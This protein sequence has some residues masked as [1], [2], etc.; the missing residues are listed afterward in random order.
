LKIL[1]IDPAVRWNV[2]DVRRVHRFCAVRL[3]E[4]LDGF[5][6]IAVGA[7]VERTL[8]ARSS[9]SDRVPSCLLIVG[10]AAAIV[11]RCDHEVAA[12]EALSW[13]V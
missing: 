4:D 10:V 5:V 3:H 8:D 9:S 2:L 6:V 7:L 11:L 1:G 13:P 12:I